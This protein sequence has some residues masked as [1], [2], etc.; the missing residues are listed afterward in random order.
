M[1]RGIGPSTWKSPT[2]VGGLAVPDV[3]GAAREGLLAMQLLEY[4]MLWLAASLI[5]LRASIC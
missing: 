2:P 4:I 5:L 1:A 3:S